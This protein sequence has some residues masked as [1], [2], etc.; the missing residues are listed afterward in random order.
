MSARQSFKPPHCGRLCQMCLGGGRVHFE[1]RTL[2]FEVPL[3]TPSWSW[4]LRRQTL[5]LALSPL[6]VFA[7]RAS[8]SMAATGTFTVQRVKSYLCSLSAPRRSSIG[9]IHC[10]L[11]HTRQSIECALAIACFLPSPFFLCLSLFHVFSLSLCLIA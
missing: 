9:F 11:A 4:S 6:T 1:A 8:S 7:G 10:S 2:P 3:A 5:L